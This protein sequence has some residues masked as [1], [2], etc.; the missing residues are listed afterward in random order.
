MIYY[1]ALFGLVLIAGLT[2]WYIFKTLKVIVILA[3]LIG[4]LFLIWSFLPESIKS[5]ITSLI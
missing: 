1:I 5:Q 2:L 3:I 4:T